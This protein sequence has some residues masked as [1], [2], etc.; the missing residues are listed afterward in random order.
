MNKAL[1]FLFLMLILGNG[2]VYGQKTIRYDLYVNDT[3]VNYSGKKAHGIAINGQIPA[4]TLEFTEGDTAEIFV[5]NAMNTTT[6]IHWHGIILPNNQDG[7]PFLTSAPIA[8]HSVYRYS[9]PIVQNGTYWYHSHTALQEQSGLYGAFIIHKKEK[10]I[11]PEFTVLLSDWTNEKPQEVLRSLKSA[12]DWYAIKKHA[13][14][15]WGEATLN[16]HFGT[17]AKQEWLRMLAMDVSDVYYNRFLVNGKTEQQL[18]SFKAGDKVRL[19]IINGSAST[20]FWIQFAGSKLNVVASDGMEVVPVD[21]DRMII[22]VAET[23]D[24]I[25]TIPENMSYQLKATAEDRTSFTAL[26][27]GDGMRMTAPVLPALKYFDGMEMM[28]GMMNFNGSMDDMGMKMSAQSMDMNVVMYPEITGDEKGEEK[29]KVVEEIQEMQHSHHTMTAASVKEIVT[30]SYTMLRASGKT[31]LPDAPFTELHFELTGNMNR[32][33]W[34]INNKTISETDKIL[35]RKGEN[36][37]IIMYNNSMMR[38]PM[39]LHGQFFRV[40]NGQGEYAPLKNVL[41]VMPMETDTIEFAAPYEGD[42]FFHCHIL[43]HMMSGMGR[44]F[45]VGSDSPNIQ[46][47]TIRHA[48]RKFERDDNMIHFHAAVAAHTQGVFAEA[49]LMN[50]DFVLDGMGMVNYNG[51]YETEITLGRYFGRMQYFKTYIGTDIRKLN[52]G[53]LDEDNADNRTVAT[54]GIQYLLPF[55]LQTDLRIDHTGK[56]R[57]QISRHDLALTSR[58]RLDGMWNTDMEYELGLR[59]ILTKRWSASANYDSHFGAGVGVTFTY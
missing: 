12:N 54:L 34:S 35:I 42:W 25:V 43:Y 17:K 8:A 7:V 32:Y 57:F 23:Y 56:V 50:K 51:D 24:V 1:L 5:H 15:N 26:W 18:T 4:P 2:K 30:L 49:M 20:Y 19:R 29:N 39:H 45:S 27:I 40:K 59:Y 33:Q 3:I 9:F 47:D 6:S 14:Q 44:V 36:V 46:I 10:A 41:D 31:T 11:I 16:G 58:L 52:D 13:T 28:N 55:F 53:H 22:A 48:N 38:H 37:R 21:V